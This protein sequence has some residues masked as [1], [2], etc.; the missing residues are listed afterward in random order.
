MLFVAHAILALDYEMVV[1]DC[2]TTIPDDGRNHFLQGAT[3]RACCARRTIC[4]SSVRLNRVASSTPSS[5][6]S[7]AHERRVAGAVADN[8]EWVVMS[9]HREIPYRSNERAL[10]LSPQSLEL[11]DAIV[12]QDVTLDGLKMTLS[13]SLPS[14][15]SGL[16]TLATNPLLHDDI[17]VQ[18]A[19][20]ALVPPDL[21]DALEAL[22]DVTGSLTEVR[23]RLEDGQTDSF[24]GEAAVVFNRLRAARA[25]QRRRDNRSERLMNNYS[26]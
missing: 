18:N 13:R 10:Y 9:T 24:G 7:C 25:E 17:A 14:L 26:A 15:W 12:G 20:R 3:P 5:I 8:V 23:S 22:D 19:I 21:R 2:G 16:A 1:C 4:A 6:V 11:L